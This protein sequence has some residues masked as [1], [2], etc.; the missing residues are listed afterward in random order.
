MLQS[1]LTV[2]HRLAFF[3]RPFSPRVIT[4]E[5]VAMLSS[6]LRGARAVKVN[7]AIMLAFVRLREIL[8]T[9]RHLTAKVEEMERRYDAHFKAIFEVIQA[10]LWCNRRNQPR[11]EKQGCLVG[12]CHEGS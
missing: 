11:G 4:Q 2:R 3:V 7:V 6:V 10:P 8:A 1:L 5:G 12:M 9:N